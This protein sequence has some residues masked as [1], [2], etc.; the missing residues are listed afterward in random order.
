MQI[1]NIQYVIIYF[2][3]FHSKS[4]WFF[5]TSINYKRK[6]YQNKMVNRGKN[7]L[8]SARKYNVSNPNDF[9]LYIPSH[10]KLLKSLLHCS[11]QICFVQ[12]QCVGWLQHIQRRMLRMHHSTNLVWHVLMCRIWI[13]TCEKHLAGPVEENNVSEEKLI[14]LS[15]HCTKLP[16]DF[17][18]PVICHSS[19]GDLFHG[20][21]CHFWRL[22]AP[23]LFHCGHSAKCLQKNIIQFIKWKKKK[24]NTAINMG[25]QR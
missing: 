1:H 14:L 13:Y 12:F 8:R 11:S 15:F 22:T 19:F 10:L 6:Y 24:K 16:N 2:A 7:W 3:S 5:Y 9:V 23:S 20:A 17:N 25:C 21:F 4:V 18:T